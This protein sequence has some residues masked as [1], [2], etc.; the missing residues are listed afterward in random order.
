M[1]N[2]ANGLFHIVTIDERAPQCGGLLVAEPFLK[3]SYFSHGVVSL[4]DYLPEEGATG[5]VM[6]KRTDYMLSDLLDGIQPGTDLRVFCGGPLGLDRIYFVHSLGS[7]IVPGAREY[8]PGLY[9]GGDF[10]AVLDYINC[11]FDTEGA[12]RFFIGYSNWT[13]GQLEREIREGTWAQAPGPLSEDELLRGEA[14]SYWHRAVRTLGSTY[15]PWQLL[16]HDASLN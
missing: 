8:S 1:K 14:D 2:L 3:D 4:I 13:P 7:D 11:G 16:P 9:V 6:N 10:D 12:I 5:I 15:R